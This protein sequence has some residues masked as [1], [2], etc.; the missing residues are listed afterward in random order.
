MPVTNN[1]APETRRRV[2]KNQVRSRGGRRGD[3]H[4]AA[5]FPMSKNGVATPGAAEAGHSSPSDAWSGLSWRLTAGRS[6]SS[7]TRIPGP[8]RITS[9][10]ARRQKSNAKR[11]RAS[12]HAVTTRRMVRPVVA[13][14]CRLQ[15]VADHQGEAPREAA[16]K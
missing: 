10:D 9:S 1:P 7:S 6:G 11:D 8:L 4:S 2:K 14:C 16:P 3:L 12:G 15:R 13:A 5:P